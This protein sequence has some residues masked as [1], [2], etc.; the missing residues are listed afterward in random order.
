MI[1]VVSITFNDKG[2]A[3][4]FSPNKLNLKNGLNVVVETERGLQFGTVV[5]EITKINEKKLNSALKKVIRVATKKD[6]ENN[7][8]NIEDAK[9]AISKC[10]ELIEKYKLNMNVMDAS[11]TLDRD[12]LVFR[13]LSDNRVDFRDLAKE[14]ASI[15]KTRIELRQIGVRDKAKQVGGIG[16]CGRPFCCSKFL[17]DFDSVS[18]NMA[19]NQNIA[20]NPNKI[21]GAC[22]RLLCCLKYENETYKE[23][24]KNAP[25]VGKKIKVDGEEGVVTAVSVLAGKYQVTLSNGTVVEKEIKN[26]N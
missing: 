17:S 8:K 14:L 21:N 15:F 25:T 2:K 6:Y 24:K 10:R 7:K 16:I 3:Y 11:Y 19:K 13:F 20:L 9:R 22:G 18:I 26:E 12:Q 5:G 23:C 4:F 1:D